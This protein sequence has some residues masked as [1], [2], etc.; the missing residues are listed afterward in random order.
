MKAWQPGTV[1]T[2]RGFL[3]VGYFDG[4]LE[5]TS[6]DHY[7]RQTASL[8]LCSLGVCIYLGVPKAPARNESPYWCLYDASGV[9][10]GYRF[11]KQVVLR[12]KVAEWSVPA[13]E[14]ALLCEY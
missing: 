14:D 1:V 9:C 4:L 5:P 12:G 3:T 8:E 2:A 11:G 10:C 7:P 13:V 6:S